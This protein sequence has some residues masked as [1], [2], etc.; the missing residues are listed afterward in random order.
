MSTNFVSNEKD[1]PVPLLDF[2]GALAAL[3]AGKNVFRAGWNGK[4]MF[5][6]QVVPEVPELP[7][8]QFAVGLEVL[9]CLCMKTADNKICVGWL[10]SQTDMLASDWAVLS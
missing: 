9:P 2:G 1:A 8:L 5:L 7:A 10:A 4:G 3:K 6:F